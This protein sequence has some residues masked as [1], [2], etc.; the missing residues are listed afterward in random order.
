MKEQDAAHS[1]EKSDLTKY[2]ETLE[3]ELTRLRSELQQE[4]ELRK[5]LV[6]CLEVHQTK[7]ISADHYWGSDTN[8]WAET[9]I[10]KAKLN[11]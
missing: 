11:N 8:E 5:E 10:E 6:N 2:C 3:T 4:R 9:L 1:F 7:W